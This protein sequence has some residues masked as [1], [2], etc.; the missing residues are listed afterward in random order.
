MLYQL[1]Y[2]SKLLLHPI[3]LPAQAHI[4]MGRKNKSL[5]ELH[6]FC[7]PAAA[8]IAAALTPTAMI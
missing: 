2:A 8:H 4:G 3:P 6:C 1:S 5:P 7:K